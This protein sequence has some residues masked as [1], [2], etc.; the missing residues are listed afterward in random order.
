MRTKYGEHRSQFFE[1]WEPETRQM[2]GTAVTIHGGWWRDRHD[3]HVMDRICAHLAR[4]GWRVHNVEFRRTGGD[5]GGWPHTLDDVLAALKAIGVVDTRPALLG[6]S[7]GGHLALM[8]SL[9]YPRLPVIGLA[10]VTDLVESYDKGL[11]EDATS[12]FVQPATAEA[13]RAAS[14]LYY[15]SAAPQLIVHGTAD[16]RV[17][18]E[19]SRDYI[20]HVRSHTDDSELYEIA[21]GDHFCLI[22]PESEVWPVIE[23]WMRAR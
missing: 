8:A 10:P 22:D 23:A 5:G 13:L 4:T 21:G 2:V 17:P 19:A 14:P 20:R 7:A 11:G 1:T 9:E 3:L 16:D 15:P 12:L 18:V 6:H